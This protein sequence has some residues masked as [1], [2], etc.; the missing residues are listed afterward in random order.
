MS[1][2]ERIE[3]ILKDKL[4]EHVLKD[5]LADSMQGK[6]KTLNTIFE[7]GLSVVAS[8][9]APRCPRLRLNLSRWLCEKGDKEI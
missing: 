7:I 5:T 2:K 8:H 9:V 4:T 3:L 6:E 1:R